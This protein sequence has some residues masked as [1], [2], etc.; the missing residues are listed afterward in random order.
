MRGR[1]LPGA[2]STLL[3]T[4]TASTC[5]LTRLPAHPCLEGHLPTRLPGLPACCICLPACLHAKSPLCQ[6]L[7][8]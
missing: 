1:A 6:E 8:S 5:E 7:E 3:T 2:T 4:R